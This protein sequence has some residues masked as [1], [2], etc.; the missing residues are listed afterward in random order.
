MNREKLEAEIKNLVGHDAKCLTYYGRDCD[1]FRS[2][3]TKNIYTAIDAYVA[4]VIGEDE[5]CPCKDIDCPIERVNLEHE[6]QHIRANIHPSATD[7]F[8]IDES[9]IKKEI[10]SDRAKYRKNPDAFPKLEPS[11]TKET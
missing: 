6:V 1:C 9:L 2:E 8:E 4:E 10:K 3:V 5:R 7:T 11:A